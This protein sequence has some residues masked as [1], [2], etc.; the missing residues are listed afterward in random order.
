[1]I[2][3]SSDMDILKHEPALFGELHFPWQVKAF[4]TG[5]TLT[6]TQLT[7]DGADFLTVGVTSGEVIYLKSLDRSP[8]GAYEIVSVDTPT[9]LTVSVLRANP[10]DVP[11]PPPPG[12]EIEWRISTFASQATAVAEELTV[13]FGIRPGDPAADYGVEDI[14]DL[15]VL[16]QASTLAVISCIYTTWANNAPDDIFWIKSRHY[17]QEFEKARLRCR[18]SIDANADGVADLTRTSGSIRM[19]R[20]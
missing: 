18:L 17:K 7:A 13:Y 15:G 10:T 6:G 16:R 19:V 14:M 1:M 8:D 5:A 3:F 11:V 2:P 9:Q 4:G 12:T 20:D